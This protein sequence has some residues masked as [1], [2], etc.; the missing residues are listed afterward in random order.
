M[1]CNNS[2]EISVNVH[3]R[4]GVTLSHFE[5]SRLQVVQTVYIEAALPVII[6]YSS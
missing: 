1:I 5:L 4:A 2:T 3:V 6:P